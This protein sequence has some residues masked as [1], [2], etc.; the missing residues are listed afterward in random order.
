MLQGTSYPHGKQEIKN[1]LKNTLRPG[2]KIC[3]MGP[4]CGTY[5]NLLGKEYEWTG[6]E[7]WTSTAQELTTTYDYIYQ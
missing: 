5:Y 1:F 6:V 4:G 2:D 3:D 7:I